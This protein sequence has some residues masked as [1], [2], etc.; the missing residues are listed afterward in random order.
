MIPTRWAMGARA[1]LLLGL[2]LGLVPR[3]ATCQLAQPEA[4]VFVSAVVRDTG[5]QPGIGPGDTILLTF[6]K[7]TNSIDIS[8]PALLAHAFKFNGACRAVVV[9]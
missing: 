4:P 8:T 2:V 5:N 6:D 7:Q 9:S 1:V 3:Q